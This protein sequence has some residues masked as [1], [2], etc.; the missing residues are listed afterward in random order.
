MTSCKVRYPI[1]HQSLAVVTPT[2]TNRSSVLRNH[3]KHSNNYQTLCW[4]DPLFWIARRSSTP[5]LRRWCLF[6]KTLESSLPFWPQH[7]PIDISKL[8]KNQYIFRTYDFPCF[9]MRS[10]FSR[11]SLIQ[12]Y[13]N[14]DSW[15]VLLWIPLLLK[16]HDDNWVIAYLLRQDFAFVPTIRV[17]RRVFCWILA[18]RALVE[19]IRISNLQSLVRD[20]CHLKPNQLSLN[21]WKKLKQNIPSVIDLCELVL[22]E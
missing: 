18:R 16:L 3:T 8:C 2:P 9:F 13:E 6:A 21:G 12:Y 22:I 14:A 17:M 20:Q 11:I 15:C 7:L 5:L 19:S 10:N 1:S 4:N